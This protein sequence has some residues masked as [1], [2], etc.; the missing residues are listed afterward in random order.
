[1]LGH[2]PAQVGVQK[3]GE[4]SAN[5]RLAQSFKLEMTQ[6]VSYIKLRL[7]KE[8]NPTDALNISLQSDNAGVPSGTTLASAALNATSVSADGYNWS[9]VS[10]SALSKLTASVNYWLV[11]QHSGALNASA[12]YLAGLDESASY[13]NGVLRV[14][15]SSN[16]LWTARTPVADLLFR[17]GLLKASDELLTEMFAAVGQGF[18]GL[19]IEA[20]TGLTMA[21]F[22]PKPL[23]GL[24]CPKNVV[25][26]RR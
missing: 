8:G 5:Q 17:M 10:F 3:I 12:Y 25:G 11:I 22:V 16:G 18:S 7:R 1:M 13:L 24:Q 4:V 26:T 20:P 9:Q 2:S 15:N 14:Y 23:D 6:D 21:S 19:L